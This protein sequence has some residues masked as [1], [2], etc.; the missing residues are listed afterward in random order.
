MITEADHRRAVNEQ[1]YRQAFLNGIDLGEYAQYVGRVVDSPDDKMYPRVTMT[2]RRSLNG[3]LPTI[4]VRP[5]AY[6]HYTT[7]SDFLAVLKYHEGRHAMQFCK[8][9]D[10]Y[11]CSLREFML[12]YLQREIDAV[13]NELM[14]V[15]V[16]PHTPE[17][18]TDTLMAWKEQLI[19]QDVIEKTSS[20]GL[21]FMNLPLIGVSSKLKRR[22]ANP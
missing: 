19:V 16:L 2:T 12:T 17:Y 22:L 7:Y 10:G 6:S 1:Q 9:Y 14:N 20:I 18:R 13:H 21:W 11:P 3:S 5:L 8:P 4:H 15:H